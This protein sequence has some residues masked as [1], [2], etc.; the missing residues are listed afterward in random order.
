MQDE[1][2]SKELLC[3]FKTKTNVSKLL[4]RQHTQVLKKMLFINYA[5]TYT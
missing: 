4:K 1:V 2:F 3:Q 5:Y